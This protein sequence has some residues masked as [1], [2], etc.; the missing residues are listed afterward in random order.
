M[1]TNAKQVL[2]EKFMETEW[3]QENKLTRKDATYLVTS[4]LSFIPELILEHKDL[5]IPNFGKFYLH[6]SKPTTKSH[7]AKP[8]ISLHV[9]ARTR[10]KFK[11]FKNLQDSVDEKTGYSGSQV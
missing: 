3:A 2:I 4:L 5:N 8:E 1:S 7:P 9:P 11:S 10:V 6:E